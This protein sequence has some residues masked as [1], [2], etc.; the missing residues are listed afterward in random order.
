MYLGFPTK[1][2]LCKHHGASYSRM[3]KA[4]LKLN[5]NTEQALEYALRS[6]CKITQ[7][8]GVTGLKAIAEHLGVTRNQLR[9]A[10]TELGLS[11]DDA[12]KYINS[13]ERKGKLDL[14]RRFM[15]TRKPVEMDPLWALA[16][17]IKL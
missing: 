6:D 3:C 16:L 14:C 15:K 11:I 5:M 9:Y 1:K 7:Y 10:V 4:M 12:I 17:G 2:A 13:D 8:Q